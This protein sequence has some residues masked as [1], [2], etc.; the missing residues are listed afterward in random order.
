MTL[1]PRR[2]VDPVGFAALLIA[3]FGWS[4][5][6]RLN[7]VYL[8]EAT[9]R[10]AVAA[11]GP[12]A[13]QAVAAM[14]AV[15]IRVEVSA[16]GFDVGGLDLLA[17]FSAPRVLLALLLQ[18]LLINLALFIFNAL[19]LPGLD[20]YAVA[21]NLL[22]GASPRLFAWFERQRLAVYAAAALVVVVLP[23]LTHGA[24]NPFAAATTGAASALYSHVIDP[25]VEPPLLGMPNI[26]TAFVT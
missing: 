11:A 19:P 3:G 21:R 14:F 15:A 1:D 24:V 6:A 16:S 13:N 9:R 26:F 7:P 17:G 2:Q 22:F 5:P 25:G 10:A 23:E 18:G 4:R 20:G 12:A 8:R